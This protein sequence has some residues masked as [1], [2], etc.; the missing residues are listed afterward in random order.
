MAVENGGV[1]FDAKLMGGA[2]DFHPAVGPK[3]SL[4]DGVVDAIVEDFCPTAGHRAETRFLQGDQYLPC[5][6]FADLR[7][8]VDLNGGEGLHVKLRKAAG[9]AAKHFKIPVEG[10]PG[11]KAAD[12]VDFGRAGSD[13]L[14]CDTEDVIM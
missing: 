4:E 14:P 13:R 12:D 1:G 2:V 8:V 3:F 11:M 9:E 10:K 7:E 5:G 6:E